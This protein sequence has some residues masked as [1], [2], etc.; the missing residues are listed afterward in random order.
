[1]KHFSRRLD[2]LGRVVIPKE[3]LRANDIVP[4]DAISIAVR[5]DSIVLQPVAQS[6]SYCGTREDLLRDGTTSVCLAC[7][8]RLSDLLQTVDKEERREA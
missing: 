4:G 5:G 2:P 3:I 7:C 6:C 1:M 8:Q